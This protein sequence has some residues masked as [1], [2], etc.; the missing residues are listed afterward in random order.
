MSPEYAMEGQYS[1]KPDV[2]SFGIL[3][4]EIIS[5]ERNTDHDKGR[6]SLNLIGHV[7]LRNG[8][9]SFDGYFFLP[10]MK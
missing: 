10:I 1:I 2:F 9:K 7:R 3:L 5:G 6:S 4:L 8:L